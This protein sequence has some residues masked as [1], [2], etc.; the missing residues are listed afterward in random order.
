MMGGELILLTWC[1]GL[2]AFLFGLAVVIV[3]KV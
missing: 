2:F 3:G 1:L